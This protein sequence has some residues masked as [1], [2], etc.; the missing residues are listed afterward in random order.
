MSAALTTARVLTTAVILTGVGASG[1]LGAVLA[2]DHQ[3]QSADQATS[4]ETWQQGWNSTGQGQDQ[5]AGLDDLP[6]FPDDSP[7]GQGVSPQGSAR[8]QGQSGVRGSF[9]SPQTRTHG[10]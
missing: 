2:I 3:R 6:A 8:Q 7:L 10:S 9:G 1:A 4:P 5:G